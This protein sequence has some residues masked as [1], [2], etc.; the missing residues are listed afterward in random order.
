MA[1]YDKWAIMVIATAIGLAGY[2]GIPWD[3]MDVTV[4]A[5]WVGAIGTIGALIGTIWLA[6]SDRRNRRQQEFALAQ[7]TAA[8]F[9][10]QIRVTRFMFEHGI[11]S[12][13][14]FTGDP[15]K[16]DLKGLYR[17]NSL[18]KMWTPAETMPLTVLH[19][20]VAMKLSAISA[21]FNT[22]QR[23][24]LAISNALRDMSLAE[25]RGFCRSQIKEYEQMRD[26][27]DDV[28]GICQYAC[29]EN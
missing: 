13:K 12:L 3:K 29:I 14:F 19:G 1:W 22:T 9:I 15:A 24:L 20:R 10:E 7:V 23:N 28:A 18:T 27:L 4:W 2:E 17:T 26:T 21:K 25:I 11:V 16:A 5:Y 8:S 6:T